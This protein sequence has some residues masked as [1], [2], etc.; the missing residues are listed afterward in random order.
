MEEPKREGFG[1]T[2]EAINKKERLSARLTDCEGDLFFIL[3]GIGFFAFVIFVFPWELPSGITEIILGFFLLL[4]G[5]LF[6]FVICGL[7]GGLL[8]IFFLKVIRVCLLIDSYSGFEKWKKSQKEYTKHLE[9]ENKKM[10]YKKIW[11]SKKNLM[12][13]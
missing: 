10:E 6:S 13:Y 5:S 1:L 11:I 3:G 7:F 4:I 8:S 9:D 12:L 2:R